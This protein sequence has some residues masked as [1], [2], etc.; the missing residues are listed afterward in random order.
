M[1]I[2]HS[3]PR[4]LPALVAL[5]AAACGQVEPPPAPSLE[6]VS[7][8]KAQHLI[9]EKPPT[10]PVVD[11]AF[12]FQELT[13]LKLTLAELRLHPS[14]LLRNPSPTARQVRL[15]VVDSSG[16]LPLSRVLAAPAALTPVRRG[17]G[18]WPGIANVV[19][20]PAEESVPPRPGDYR[21]YL[22]AETA[23]S[24]ALARRLVLVTV[25][26]PAS[27]TP[28]TAEWTT[29]VFKFAPFARARAGASEH[30]ELRCAPDHRAPG[31]G[32]LPGFLRHVMGP[33]IRD[34]ELPLAIT[35]SPPLLSG[36][37]R[38][39]DTL[40]RRMLGVLYEK[41]RVDGALV[42]WKGTPL[43]AGGPGAPAKLALDFTSLD[44]PG[45]YRGT[46]SLA[47][48]GGTGNVDLRVR[49][50]HDWP[51]VVM[52]LL[53]G[54]LLSTWLRAYVRTRR[55][56]LELEET[57]ARLVSTI[58]ATDV[59]FRALDRPQDGKHPY[60]VDAALPRDLHRIDLRIRR[61]ARDRTPLEPG[62]AENEKLRA[63]LD[64]CEKKVITW[65]KFLHLLQDLRAEL[66][67]GADVAARLHR[68]DP[69]LPEVL[70][71]AEERF[72]GRALTTAELGPV[73]QEVEAS[74]RL[75]TS[76][77]E[78][79][80]GALSLRDAGA[81][82]GSKVAAQAEAGRAVDKAVQALFAAT[83][84]QE[85]DAVAA[86][87]HT[88][89]ARLGAVRPAFARRMVNTM[90]GRG[91]AASA[92]QEASRASAPASAADAAQARLLKREIASVGVPIPFRNGSKMVWAWGVVSSVDPGERERRARQGR[93]LSDLGYLLVTTTVAV[94]TGFNELYLD[95]FG[96]GTMQDYLLA[97]L[98]GFGAKLGI[99][100]VRVAVE[101]GRIPWPGRKDAA[102]GAQATPA[103]STQTTVTPASATQTPTP[104]QA[105]STKPQTGTQTGTQAVAPG[106]GMPQGEGDG[107]T[108]GE[109][110][111]KTDAKTDEKA[112]PAMMAAAN[113]TP[114]VP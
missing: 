35:G 90:L 108:D 87:L 41:D 53:F 91:D 32:I 47:S 95:A 39:G 14:V 65:K 71:D 8:V 111:G 46:I 104:S 43:K 92:G 102:P 20:K 27:I 37:V 33:C 52:A 68:G 36:E 93:Q 79:A 89:E 83:D 18:P 101:G 67:H 2:L 19:L 24:T 110:D 34:S 26:D 6:E 31:T 100:T 29:Q 56:V 80:D 45:E 16:E 42:W 11:T 81:V 38:E 28:M 61:H 59:A 25:P 84:A 99:D 15:A 22:V 109:A 70:R 72:A 86:T 77:G 73:H 51:Y 58:E 13:D 106:A 66:D 64:E 112:E 30:A 23:D 94:L 50:T 75:V 114:P 3:A 44:Y 40:Q 74:C 1:R 49:V 54:V 98:W 69:G 97:V 7:E 85:V 107:K 10:P 57:R 105:P 82:P 5:S 63:E 9:R 113:G 55:A 78:V 62:S 17:A 4:L 103:S 96:F 60:E 88:V 48:V 21:G 12:R 76:W